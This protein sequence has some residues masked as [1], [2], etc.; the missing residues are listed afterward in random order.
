[1]TSFKKKLIVLL[2]ALFAA[3][4]LGAG[5]LFLPAGSSY[6]AGGIE[7]SEEKY[8]KIEN[9]V[10]NGL[11]DEAISKI[12]RVEFTI[13][14]PATVTA[15]GDGNDKTGT[16]P[17]ANLLFSNSQYNI[18]QYLTGVAFV[19]PEKIT[20]IGYRAFVNCTALKNIDLSQLTA[21]TDLDV[22]VF[23]DCVSLTTITFPSGITA[24]PDYFF[25]GCVKLTTVNFSGEVDSIGMSA[26]SNCGQLSITLPESLTKIGAS[27]FFG[28]S[29]L[30]SVTVPDTV[31]DLGESVFANCVNLVTVTLPK[32]I[33]AI[34]AYLFQNC[35]KLS[36]F[37]I[38]DTVTQIGKYAL[39]NC[40]ALDKITVPSGVTNIGLNAFYG[41][42]SVTRINYFAAN[43][44]VEASPFAMSADAYGR[45][46]GVEVYVGDPSMAAVT[47]LP[48]RLFAG[49]KSITKVLFRNVDLHNGVQDFGTNVFNGCSSLAEV[50]FGDMCNISVINEGAFEGCISLHT[51][52]HIEKIKLETIGA[53][54]FY[55]CRSLNT[56]IIGAEVTGINN[57]A[58]F[59][60]ETLIEVQNLSGLKIEAGKETATDGKVA[61][62]A[63][64]VYGAG[65][66]SRISTNPS[67]YVFY[68][69]TTVGASEVLLIGYIGS[70][71]A[72]MLPS[73][74]NSYTYNIYKS[75]FKG[76]TE[77]TSIG[78]SGNAASTTNAKK[79]GESAFE[80]CTAL[81][82][83]DLPRGLEEVGANLFQGCT[84]LTNV[85]FNS[86]DRLSTI[87]DNMFR[88][89]NELRTIEI[90]SKVRLIN[91]YAFSGCSELR[92]VTFGGNVVQT[93]KGHAFDGCS[94]LTAVM[95]PLS[96]TTVEAG[97][98]ENC[99]SLKFVYLPDSADF[100]ADVFKNCS[101]ELILISKD[102]TCYNQ[103]IN[104]PGLKAFA[105]GGRLTYLVK[106]KLMYDDGCAEHTV[107]KLYNMQGDLSQNTTT[108]I[109]S[110]TG[111]MPIQGG[112]DDTQIYVESVWFEEESYVTQ[113]GIDELEEKLSV[114]GVSEITLYARYFAHPNLTVPS[115]V[116]Y[117]VGKNYS[118]KDLL[119]QIFR[120]DGKA[121]SAARAE[122]LTRTF[123]FSI[124]SH[125]F[126]NGTPD[127][128]W[129][130]EA[131]KLITDAGTYVLSVTLPTDGSYGGWSNSK[132]VEFTI[133][134]GK[135]DITDLLVWKALAPDI[136]AD[137]NG[138]L[139]TETLYFYNGTH[140]PYLEELE[141]QTPT[142]KVN[143][144]N[145]YTVYTGSKITIRLEWIDDIHNYGSIGS[146]FGN[147]HTEAGTYDATAILS[148]FNN[149]IFT[150]RTD[151]ATL[152]MLNTLNLEFAYGENGTVIV[153]KKWYIA[154]SNVNQL[155]SSDENGGL[156]DI[157][158]ELN[159]G[160]GSHIPFRPELSK[161]PLQAPEKLT[162]TLSFTDADGNVLAF[163]D[164]KKIAITEYEKYFNSSMPA[165]SYIAK[166][167]IADGI[168]ENGNIVT[169]D[170]QGKEFRF[171]VKELNVTK[172]DVNQVKGM[173]SNIDVPYTN[174]ALNFAGADAVAL[175]N[176][177]YPQSTPH[178]NYIWAGYSEYYT[179]FEIRYRVVRVGED[180]A[181]ENY[182]TEDEY[183]SGGSGMVKPQAIGSYTIYY[184]ISAP[185]YGGTI[186]GS[187][188]LNITHTLRPVLPAFDYDGSN[189]LN[190]VI[191]NL[192]RTVGLEYFDIYTM[193]DYSKLSESDSLKR[194]TISAP[195]S[196]RI[197][198]MFN[199]SKNDAYSEIGTHKIF[200]KIKE[201][202]VSYI[203]WDEATTDGYLYLTIDIIPSAN[204]LFVTEWEFGRFNDSVNAPELK[205]SYGAGTEYAFI[206]KL[207]NGS[208]NDTYFYYTNP[209]LS[210]SI[211]EGHAFKDA[212]VGEYLLN[213]HA[214]VNNQTMF[215]IEDY[216]VTVHKINIDFAKAPYLGGWTYGQLK[217]DT[218]VDSQIKAVLAMGV[219]INPEIKNEIVIKYSTAANYE[220]GRTPVSSIAAL[221]Q[222][223]YLPSGEYYAIL[224]RE[225][226]GNYEALSYAIK[227]SVLKAPNYW[228]T[229]PE[230]KVVA[231]ITTETIFDL[232]KTVYDAQATVKI[233]L[234]AEG[235]EQWRNVKDKDFPYANVSGGII[236]G[237]YQMRITVGSE[238]LAE[239]QQTVSLKIDSTAGELPPD[240]NGGTDVAEDGISDVAVIVATVVLAVVAAAVIAAGAVITVLRNKKA[241]AEYLKTVKSEMK[242]R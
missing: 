186:S 170:P 98:F 6:A 222:N 159:Y 175:L 226:D 181:D 215:K 28:C 115:D 41:L 30:T 16:D 101:Q 67:G 109:W 224:T 76:N 158:A 127:G 57:N 27:A 65:G 110:S 126:V 120:E 217:S 230:D 141:N 201:G 79:I 9:G 105:D 169:G 21:L 142:E 14:L 113:V 91:T 55:N 132:T 152:S 104:K 106:L 136:A 46:G 192:E 150:Y 32:D 207:K 121:I 209:V 70:E 62:Y 89:C 138:N 107:N 125:T 163:N 87:S 93:V 116:A 160:D 100:K 166:F 77:I 22:G 99:A 234:K 17:T 196:L 211:P 72:L 156:F 102:L 112:H 123:S 148:P 188:K 190:S 154:I 97:C 147:E 137:G 122:E 92:T 135:V 171:T 13:K 162:F 82:S 73:G 111:R 239:L 11:T 81:T 26:F 149:Y 78:F 10:F 44:S 63:K 29:A 129:S 174:N 51:V 58:F 182:Y 12:G 155:L 191:R 52:K 34:P 3:I 205:V 176:R 218:D 69:D 31:T 134:A 164:G 8:F 35:Y 119:I 59:G 66:S 108:L 153:K 145:S 18:S 237:T 84:S 19:A 20:K 131:G 36:N 220:E 200:L 146:Y 37:D 179:P 1:M 203:K 228:I 184:I 210:A 216:G 229:E 143:K 213:A 183:A 197:K 173:L 167:F 172:T 53:Q 68:A 117:E 233:E 4:S 187:Y 198:N 199:L 114:E 194:E 185:N 49:H 133:T 144:S 124:I 54:A 202:Y 206:M 240:T 60:C 24:V 2:F 5:L 103:D 225:A 130:W 64:Y 39:S 168:D 241:N 151:T 80:G 193:L 86:N 118:V 231:G 208:S 223:G 40:I 85:N 56:V 214:T 177:L 45:S 15:I 33:D 180:N 42:D 23:R 43:A 7:L 235:G 48:Q 242:R 165:G 221:A 74:Y 140:T 219:G 227:F 238:D 195:D 88:N 96:V 50:Q 90:P 47:K 38:P 75:A 25:R 139:E 71:T 94:S 83:V 212:P 236:D 161:I 232:F 157:P 61:L 128:E 178:S 189:V 95:L 204:S